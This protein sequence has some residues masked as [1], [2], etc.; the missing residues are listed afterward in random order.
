MRQ[1]ACLQIIH[2]LV[3]RDTRT[4]NHQ[5]VLRANDSWLRV[6]SHRALLLV[7]PYLGIV[8]AS[9]STLLNFQVLFVLV[10]IV[11]ACDLPFA[12]Q[13]VEIKLFHLGKTACVGK[14]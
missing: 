1:P 4:G 7:L 6:N 2:K 10:D 11:M 14:R 3:Q 5:T 12:Q 13:H 9:F 8:T